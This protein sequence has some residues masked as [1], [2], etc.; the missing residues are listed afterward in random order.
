[1]GN[2]A[3][4]SPRN[5]SKSQK[6]KSPPS[7]DRSQVVS[8]G[9]AKFYD[10][11]ESSGYYTCKPDVVAAT[12]DLPAYYFTAS[13]LHNAKKV[14]KSHDAGLNRIFSVTD[15]QK[16][17]VRQMAWSTSNRKSDNDTVSVIYFITFK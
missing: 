14:S 12:K 1:M 4:D 6:V 2:S 9:T 3:S 7:V 5:Q 11:V 15:G 8:P 10:S 13:Q 16:P 17:D